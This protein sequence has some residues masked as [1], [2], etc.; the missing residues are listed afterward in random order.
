MSK[1]NERDISTESGPEIT[2]EISRQIKIDEIKG[3]HLDLVIEASDRERQ[4]LAKRFDLIELEYF[5]AHLSFTISVNK[6]E[7]YL[8][9]SFSAQ[10][11]QRCVVTLEPVPGAITGA[12]NCVYSADVAPEDIEI[13]DF[14]S[15]T[16][17]PPESIVDG[18]FDVGAMLTEQFG[19]ELEPFPRSPNADF[20]ELKQAAGDKLDSGE[21]NNPFA[22]LK[23]LK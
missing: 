2:P 6:A 14:D 15:A 7:V 12:Y 10:V 18:M 5:T 8:K 16:E 3:D 4:A 11:T 23:K 9:A 13:I 17:D 21:S 1:E 22:V 20:E 19:L